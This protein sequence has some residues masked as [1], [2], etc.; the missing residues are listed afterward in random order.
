MSEC[1]VCGGDVETAPDVLEGE[2]IDCPECG[3]EL[4]V[5][6]VSPLTLIE[7]PTEAEDWGE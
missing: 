3:L 2:L 7:A 6:S 1:P 4:E 5:S